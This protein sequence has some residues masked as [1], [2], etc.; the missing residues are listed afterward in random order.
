MKID[1]KM[2]D[3]EK[4]TPILRSRLVER[5]CIAPTFRKVVLWGCTKPNEKTFKQH[6]E[7]GNMNRDIKEFLKNNLDKL[8]VK[9]CLNYDVTFL[10][11][12]I[13]YAC[14]NVAHLSSKKYKNVSKDGSTLEFFLKE[15]K[16][17]RNR[18]VHEY[19]AAASFDELERIRKTL[20]TLLLKAAILYG[21][22]EVIRDQAISELNNELHRI[23]NQKYNRDWVVN[24]IKEA[25]CCQAISELKINRAEN[26][27]GKY[28]ASAL[29]MTCFD[30]KSSKTQKKIS[31]QQLVHNIQ[32]QFILVQGEPRSGKTLLMN[33]LVDE[34]LEYA[35]ELQVHIVI[36]LAC[37]AS[38]EDN[39]AGLLKEKIPKT[40][41]FLEDSSVS[42]AASQVSIIFLVDGFD[43]ATE[44]SKKLLFDLLDKS[45]S[46]PTLNWKFIISSRPHAWK[47]IH[48]ECKIRKISSIFNIILQ[49]FS[50]TLEN[51]G[52]HF[53][54]LLKEITKDMTRKIRDNCPSNKNPSSTASEVIELLMSQS[55]ELYSLS[56]KPFLTE[57]QFVKLLESFNSNTKKNINFDNV[58]HCIFIHE[59]GGYK[60]LHDGLEEYLSA[61]WLVLKLKDWRPSGMTSRV[62]RILGHWQ[63]FRTHANPF[64]EIIGDSSPEVLK[65]WA[66]VLF[67]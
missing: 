12:L 51:K 40:L 62:G 56:E 59:N 29:K 38:D 53:K 54:S 18:I 25:I 34:Y 45:S 11:T 41:G 46:C 44:N 63:P 60:F 31:M 6:I 14:E 2:S 21:K 26:N 28:V 1:R 24:F 32:S 42:D 57:K 58:L 27:A 36:Y 8:D 15:A 52:S 30:E 4:D 49:P 16:D 64:L 22:E 23:K 39:F 33:C 19:D 9:D 17:C 43:E 48:N 35:H 13:H 5:D 20:E 55:F 3:L 61:K 37:R 7:E 67:Y 65:R 50:S 66:G 47:K 10:Y